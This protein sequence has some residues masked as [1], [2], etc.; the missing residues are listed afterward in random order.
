MGLFRRDRGQRTEAPAT[1]DSEPSGR[2]ATPPS[3]D[4]D[5]PDAP[6]PGAAAQ[7]D[8]NPA[9]TAEPE[10]PEGLAGP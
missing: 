5:H 3:R 8:L 1:L 4:P 9:A 10:P 6:G 7:T 2:E